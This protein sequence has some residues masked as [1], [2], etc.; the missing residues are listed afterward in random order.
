MAGRSTTMQQ[1]LKNDKEDK[2]EEIAILI[3]SKENYE[4][5][6]G[7]DFAELVDKVR[8]FDYANKVEVDE[9]VFLE[10]QYIINDEIV[11]EGMD[12]QDTVNDYGIRLYKAYDEM[13][14]QCEEE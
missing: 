8:F 6:K 3:F 9:N 4:I 11:L 10:F 1:E 5:I 12:N 13:L 2:K 14:E 7:V